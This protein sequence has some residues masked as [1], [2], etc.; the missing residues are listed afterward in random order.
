MQARIQVQIKWSVFV[1]FYLVVSSKI[2]PIS[3]KRV[4]LDY[5]GLVE[6]R[7]LSQQLNEK[8]QNPFFH[9]VTKFSS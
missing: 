6:Y 2:V 1:I 7:Q 5:E 3:M 4:C 9:N 8:H